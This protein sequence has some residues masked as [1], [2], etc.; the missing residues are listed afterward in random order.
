MNTYTIFQYVHQFFSDTM[1][2]PGARA[3]LDVAMSYIGEHWDRLSREDQ[4][5][6]E[7]TLTQIVDREL[8]ID[9]GSPIISH[10]IGTPQPM[11]KL[12]MIFQMQDEPIPRMIVSSPD[13]MNMLNRHR[14]RPWTEYEDQRLICAI[15]RFGFESWISVASFVGN[16]RTRS[17]CSQRWN[18]CLNPKISKGTW[19]KEDEEKLLKLAKEH[20]KKSWTKIAQEFG[21]RSDVQ[22]RYRYRQ[23]LKERATTKKV[24]E[25]ALELDSDS[26][27][28]WGSDKRSRDDGH[29]LASSGA[30]PA[31]MKHDPGS[32]YDETVF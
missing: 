27:E 31:P 3:L 24:L 13:P 16:G 20:G 23:L 11:M 17:Q 30:K 15:Y 26:D 1:S 25:T 21:N 7:R 2:N 29:G 12:K 28:F 32:V 5:T 9:V 22:C 19:S 4:K 14:A 10:I 6:V 18:R 8:S